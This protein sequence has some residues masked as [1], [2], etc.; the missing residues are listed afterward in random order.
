EPHQLIYLDAKVHEHGGNFSQGQRQLIALARALARRSKIIIMD[1]ATASVDFRTDRLIQETIREEF[2]EATV[3]TIAHRLRTVMDYDRVL[4]LGKIIEFES[5]YLLLQNPRS[6]F[7]RMCELSGE[8]EDLMKI[9]KK[10]FKENK[11]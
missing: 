6:M 10:N 1:E 11:S 4:V 3:I 7:K 8:Y 5:P 2:S 9:A